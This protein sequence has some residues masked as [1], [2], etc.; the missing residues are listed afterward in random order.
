M[1]SS[2]DREV[3]PSSPAHGPGLFAAARHHP[4]IVLT[5]IVTGIVLAALVSLALPVKYTA[6]SRLVLGDQND[7][8]VFRNV[9]DL[10]PTAKAQ[11]AAQVM[12]SPDVWDRASQLLGGKL[13]ADQIKN[14]VE[15]APG[16]NNPLVTITA[17]ASV[18]N[19]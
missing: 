13:T 9:T 2:L 3:G 14:G 10:N 8:T 11:Q 18:A 19:K 5:A 12:R 7:S 6:Q 17:T 15:V 4:L 16:D 1:S